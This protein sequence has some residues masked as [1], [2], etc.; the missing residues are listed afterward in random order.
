MA[1]DM[2]APPERIAAFCDGATGGNLAGVV[3]GD[4][5]PD[6]ADMQR[7]AAEI[8]YSETAFAAPHGAAWRVRYFAPVREVA[9]CGHAT[10]ALG[11]ALACRFGDGVYA[12]QLNDS[13]IFVEGRRDG[14]G[15]SAALTSPPTRSGPVAA[16]VL[17]D[18]LALFALTAA[19]LAAAPAP[20]IANAGNDHLILVLT[21]RATLAAMA[22]D[23]A[24]GAAFMKAHDFTTISLLVAQT[25]RLFHSRNAFAS[26]GVSEDPATGAAA[27]ALGG[28]LRDV[29]WPH[30]GVIDIVQGEDMGARSLLRVEI[31]DTP[32]ESVRVSGTARVL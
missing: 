25:P 23:L 14:T 18:A 21:D 22:Y 6:P 29:G 3:I 31:G 19:D 26:G 10:I 17:K 27:A 5:L 30:G 4:T 9:F 11:A 7:I 8:G 28:Y 20:A 16:G 1:H 15:I 13:A 24:A 12:L 2:T 32:G